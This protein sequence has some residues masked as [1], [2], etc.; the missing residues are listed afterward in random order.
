MK[1]SSLPCVFLQIVTFW[2]LDPNIGGRIGIRRKEDDKLEHQ[3]HGNDILFLRRLMLFISTD[4]S[5]F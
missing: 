5:R 1:S 3:F 4:T 2:F